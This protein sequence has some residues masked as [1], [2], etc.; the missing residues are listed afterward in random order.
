MDKKELRKEIRVR[1]KSCTSQVLLDLSLQITAKIESHPKFNEAKNIM[2]YH[3]LDDEVNTHLLVEKYKDVKNIILPVVVGDELELR[4]YN[5]NLKQGAFNILEPDGELWTDN[6]AIELAI[7][8]GMAF[9]SEC[10]RL[11]RGK[12]YYDKTLCHL[13]CYKIGVCF[14]FQYLEHIPH[15]EHDIKMNEIITLEHT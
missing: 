2:L 13:K 15:E 8:P 3:S 10:N 1:K 14:P 9:D 11:G 4:L 7:I 6:E 5:G 12:G